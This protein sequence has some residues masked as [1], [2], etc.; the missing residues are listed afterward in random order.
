MKTTFSIKFAVPFTFQMEFFSREN[1]VGKTGFK[2]NQL[3]TLPLFF[4]VSGDVQHWLNLSCRLEDILKVTVWAICLSLWI[5]KQTLHR[6]KWT[7]TRIEFCI[8]SLL[9]MY[10][11]L[12]GMIFPVK[13][14]L[15]KSGQPCSKLR[16]LFLK[17]S[18]KFPNGF[19]I[20]LRSSMA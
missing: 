5:L 8:F 10:L 7:H 20:Y 6:V 2:A 11:V 14:V 1:T 9:G 13:N 19:S 3:Y 15:F 12:S 4:S 16:F 17:K 18:G